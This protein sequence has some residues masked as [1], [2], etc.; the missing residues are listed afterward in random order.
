M[1]DKIIRAIPRHQCYVELFF[2]GGGIYFLRP[3]PSK[4]EVI[5]DINGELINLYRCVQHHPEELLRILEWSLA[6]RQEYSR[7]KNSVRWYY[8]G[9]TYNN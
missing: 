5:N 6:S 4:V 2:G 3:T 7:A 8:F 1:A 9:A